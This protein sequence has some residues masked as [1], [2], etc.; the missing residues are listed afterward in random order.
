VLPG[1]KSSLTKT[2]SGLVRR[3]VR[4]A[5]QLVVPVRAATR[6]TFSLAHDVLLR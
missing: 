5:A 4:G 1:S 3:T 6:R 2:R